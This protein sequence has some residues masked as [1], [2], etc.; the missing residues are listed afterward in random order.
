M[1]H[2]GMRLCSLSVYSEMVKIAVKHSCMTSAL[3][4]YLMSFT[5]M[6]ELITGITILYALD[7]VTLL[8]AIIGLFGICKEKKWALV[9]VSLTNT[10][11]VSLQTHDAVCFCLPQLGIWWLIETERSNQASPYEFITS[12]WIVMGFWHCL[13]WP[14]FLLFFMFYTNI[15]LQIWCDTSYQPVVVL[16]LIG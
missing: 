7:I 12:L 14:Q 8:L 1:E 10:S 4:D 16:R 6:D 5:Q 15:S 13:L 9:L 3:S 11:C 2:G